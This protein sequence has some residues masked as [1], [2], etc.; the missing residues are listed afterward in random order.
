[1]P[2]VDGPKLI[3]VLWADA[4]RKVEGPDSQGAP[5][6]PEDVW[7]EMQMTITKLGLKLD[8]VP[9]VGPS[10]TRPADIDGVPAEEYIR[11]ASGFTGEG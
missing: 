1:V 4:L 6:L 11:A 2:E 5:I 3:Q 10:A 8:L 7:A 9:L